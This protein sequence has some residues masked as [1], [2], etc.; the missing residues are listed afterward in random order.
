[1]NARP[2]TSKSSRDLRARAGRQTADRCAAPHAALDRCLDPESYQAEND[3]R[4]E[5][6]STTPTIRR[7][8]SLSQIQTGDHRP[9]RAAG[10]KEFR[11]LGGRDGGVGQMNARRNSTEN[12]RR[13]P[14]APE[15]EGDRPA[16]RSS[17]ATAIHPAVL[18][19]ARLLGRQSAIEFLRSGASAPE[20]SSQRRSK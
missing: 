6:S 20:P 16:A 3:R 8:I 7:N 18:A 15:A 13:T 1:M 10:R 11:T 14:E 4:P 12:K 9:I 5:L 2:M 17:A 19:V